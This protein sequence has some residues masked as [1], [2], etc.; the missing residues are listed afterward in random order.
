MTGQTISPNGVHVSGDFQTIA[1]FSG[2]DWNSATCTMAQEDTTNIYSI[3]VDIPAFMKYEYRFINGDLFYE[4]EFVPVES[5]VGY[6]FVDNRW[7]YVDSLANDTTFVGAILFGGN[8]PAGKK[9]VRLLVDMSQETVSAHG[10]YVAGNYNNWD[11]KAA[12][13]YNFQDNIFE[14]IQYVDSASYEYKF[15]NGY[16]ASEAETI[17]TA[18]ATNGS[19]TITVNIDTILSAVCY[20]SCIACQTGIKENE[21][22]L[23]SIYPNPSRGNI[24]LALNQPHNQITVYDVKGNLLYLYKDFSSSTLTI[25][26][27]KAGAYIVKVSNLK[28]ESFSYKFIVQ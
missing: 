14:V 9:L 16:N 17:P 7:L 4:S 12:A 19:R 28:S 5:R 6:D 22:Q 23:I 21:K 13:L 11:Y 2:G 15:S 25:D 18:C 26:N 10:V 1:G 20:A 3:V 27:L 24:T 8:A